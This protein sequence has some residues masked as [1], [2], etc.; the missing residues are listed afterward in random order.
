[1]A[2]LLDINCETYRYSVHFEK[3]E[4]SVALSVGNYSPIVVKIGLLNC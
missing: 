1:M 2:L 3:S 4:T